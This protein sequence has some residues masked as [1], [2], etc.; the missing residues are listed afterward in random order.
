MCD[1]THY[2]AVSIEDLEGQ[3]SVFILSN[4]GASTSEKHEVEIDGRA[5]QWT[6]PYHYFDK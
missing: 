5:Y 2:T 6:G 4:Q 3:T 1:D